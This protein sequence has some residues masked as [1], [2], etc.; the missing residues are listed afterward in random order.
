MIEK[1]AGRFLRWCIGKIGWLT[2][3]SLSL[4]F[5]IFS[6]LVYGLAD[7]IRGIDIELLLPLAL[8]G[9][10]FGWWLGR[11]S[12]SKR[13]ALLVAAALGF[14]IVLYR[15]GRLGD[16]TLE[17][18]RALANIQIIDQ[19]QQLDWGPLWAALTNFS[20][21]FGTLITRT[22][23]WTW[24]VAR[25]QQAYDPIAIAVVWSMIIWGLAIW[26]AWSVRRWRRPLLATVPAGALLAGILNYLNRGAVIILPMMGAILLLM[27]LIRYSDRE[28]SWRTRGI[29]YSEDL[30]LEYFLA[31]GA[32]SILVISIAALAPSLSI[33]NIAHYAQELFQGKP[34]ETSPIAESFGL[35]D[36]EAQGDDFYGLYAAGLP[37]SHLLGSGPEL[38]EQIVMLVETNDPSF[39]AS[40]VNQTFPPQRYYWRSLTYDRYLS[41][42]WGTRKTEAI[43]YS[44]NQTVFNPENVSLV[45]QNP[46]RRFMQQS[47]K[48]SE[49]LA[50]MLYNTGTLIT[51]DSDYQVAWRIAPIDQVPVDQ[52]NTSDMFGALINANTYQAISVMPNIGVA[53]LRASGENYPAWVT[54]RYLALPITVPERVITLAL[55]LTAT[56]PTPYDRAK[57]IEYYLRG[58]PYNLDIPAPPSNRDVVDYFLFTLGEGYCDY[59][60]SAMVVLARA[61]GLPSRLV[62]GYANGMY[63]AENDQY[64]VT[65]ADA[66]S[67]PEIYFPTIGW[68][69]FEPTAG[70]PPLEYPQDIPSREVD[71]FVSSFQITPEISQRNLLN[72]LINWTSRIIAVFLI[73]ILAW[74]LMDRWRLRHLEPAITV[75]MLYRRLYRNG[76]KIAIAMKRGDT[77]N[78]FA[79]SLKNS[80]SSTAEGNRWGSSLTPASQEVHQLTDIYS[81]SIYSTHPPIDKDRNRAIQ[82]WNRLRWRLF[83]ARLLGKIHR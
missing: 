54:E 19:S 25:G 73:I 46:S 42:G 32:L 67:W 7:T 40:D 36:R 75:S 49:D 3:L 27:A 58:F 79:T 66:H 20:A 24:R 6:M 78:E 9:L 1:K 11:F 17:I 21:S 51:A 80:I 5:L 38:A 63:D 72:T 16:P 12:I 2:L 13:W 22:S 34:G 83:L 71:E 77:P 64:I 81:R 10:L 41:S 76:R 47:V 57:A 52:T 26:A 28:R 37:R 44:A 8:L 61:A 55:D 29:D 56:E 30:R 33:Q 68:V 39:S 50:G 4:L 18:I 43:N 60:A 15:V 74:F 53:Q 69:E 62:I 23:S 35:K 70:L 31:S 59:Y 45:T 14:G 48:V 65:A 82:T